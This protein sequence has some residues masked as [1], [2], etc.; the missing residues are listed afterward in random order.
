[1]RN[2]T[3]REEEEDNRGGG[4]GGGGGGVFVE[5]GRGKTQEMDQV[6]CDNKSC[7]MK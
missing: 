4:G 2:H 5:M 3:C 7:E 1:M 6:A